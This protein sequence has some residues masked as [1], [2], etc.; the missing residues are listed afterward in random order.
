MNLF[1]MVAENFSASGC[2]V[3]AALWYLFES[4]C[5][6]L[7]FEFLCC[8]FIFVY[9]VGGGCAE[10]LFCPHGGC[11]C[12]CSLPGGCGWVCVALVTDVLGLF[13]FSFPVDVVGCVLFRAWRI[14]VVAGVVLLFSWALVLLAECGL[15][16][17]CCVVLVVRS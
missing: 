5:S 16:R 11:G 9:F 2:V 4:A 14:G 13:S 6:R 8:E 3:A 1:L 17:V 12:C 10:A 15:R 7:L